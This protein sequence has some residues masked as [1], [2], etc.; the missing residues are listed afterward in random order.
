MTTALMTT[1]APLASAG[2]AGCTPSAAQDAVALDGLGT[3][4]VREYKTSTG[5]YAEVWREANG[6]DGLQLYS[7]MACGES[8]D[9]LEQRLCT[10]GCSIAL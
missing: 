8:A 1:L 10:A 2:Y 5:T 6:L 4:Y 7:G 3:R 9:V